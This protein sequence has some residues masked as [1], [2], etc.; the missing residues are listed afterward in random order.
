MQEI[1]LKLGFAGNVKLRN[2]TEVNSISYIRGRKIITKH[3]GYRIFELDY[4]GLT[5][6]ISRK[7]IREVY[8]KGKIYSCEVPNHILYVRRNGVPI[9]SGNS[10]GGFLIQIDD[11][12]DAHQK[13]MR[14]TV[15]RFCMTV[16]QD[17]YVIGLDAILDIMMDIALTD[18]CA[19]AE[20]VYEKEVEFNDYLD[21]Q[22]PVEEI[23]GLDG[24]KIKVLK[25]KVMT[26]A[27]WKSLGGITRL[28]I[29]EDSYTRL[30]PYRHPISGEVLYWTLDEKSSTPNAGLTY[31]D[32]VNRE[33]KK[34]I[35]KFHPWEIFWLSWNKHGTNLKGL[36]LIQP[37]YSIAKMAQIIQTS[38]GKGY[39]RW[40]NKKYFFVCVPP[41]TEILTTEG[42]KSI[43][44]IAGEI[45]KEFK[46][47]IELNVERNYKLITCNGEA[48][49]EKVY[50]RPY[51]GKLITIK[52]EMLDAISFTPEHPILIAKK[53]RIR[54][55]EGHEQYIVKYE[56]DGFTKAEDVK[57]GDYVIVPKFKEDRDF[58]MGFPDLSHR[59]GRGYGR[60]PIPIQS[61][62]LSEDL[63]KLFGWYLAE[64]SIT[65]YAVHFALNITEEDYALE[66]A[67]LSWEF[68]GLHTTISK[69]EE[70]HVIEVSINSKVFAEFMMETFGC[71]A[72]DKH[73]PSSFL[74]WKPNILKALISR[75]VKGDGSLGKDNWIRLKLNSQ[76]LQRQLQLALLKIGY[77][78]SLFPVLREPISEIQGREIHQN[79]AWV[80]T[81]NENSKIIVEDENN[82]YFRINNITTKDYSG[83]VYNLR[84]TSGEFNVPFATHNC[85]T[86][87]RPWN[88]VYRQ[89]FLKAMEKMIANNWVGTPVPW[90]FDIK[91]IGG[92]A[93]IFDGKNIL[94]HLIS[95][96]AAGMQ[97][98]LDFLESGRTQASD[99]SWLA[100]TVRYGRS[101]NQIRRAMEHQLFETHLRCK[102]GSTVKESRKGPNQKD[103]P[104]YIPKLQWKAEGQW[105]KDAKMKTL[106]GLLNVANPID[107]PL[108]IPIQKEMG[109][110]LGI[111]EIDWTE[112]E[113]LFDTQ[114]KTRLAT[115]KIDK[116]KTEAKLEAIEQMTSE[117]LANIPEPQPQK[118]QTPEE[119]LKEQGEKRQ[120]KGVSRTT[121][122]TGTES[123]KG[124]AKG[125]G[126][127]RKVAET[128]EFEIPQEIIDKIKKAAIEEDD[129][130]M[131]RILKKLQLETLQKKKEQQEKLDEEI[132]KVKKKQ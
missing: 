129:K 128:I 25:P 67:E 74:Y 15:K 130:G 1:L 63:A 71:G 39:N 10:G 108:K 14:E 34:T 57:V 35:I 24:K 125:M 53:N 120:E 111:G 65:D 40:A 92:E 82:Y 3:Q 23:I 115:A 106:T 7:D 47:K 37:V 52:A 30:I 81:W 62:C 18:G 5:P 95:M 118:P 28:K 48:I 102:F 131:E 46:E 76:L 12:K 60:N 124:L 93:S 113:D 42:Y 119:K 105:L 116:L 99:K 61:Q 84:S 58:W 114:N 38:V 13:E 85:G 126:G 17:Q 2:S 27:L 19:A 33:K 49:I 55:K 20:I 78:A 110:T 54:T 66:I 72:N 86:E 32:I 88:K 117:E 101:Q 109:A 123:K 8:Y 103:L 80:L 68:L 56:I 89:E 69:K 51:I 73:L 70:E 87:R 64:G 83:F 127:T 31:E 104:I 79:P 4:R 122:E 59:E 50:K 22:T 26:D 100:W 94:D 132:E 21:E 11:P 45:A 36:S 6:I 9:W 29:I 97:Y 43:E 75:I 107:Y 16:F 96:I 98:P 77:R 112:I 41:E 90:G 91:E 121:K 44:E